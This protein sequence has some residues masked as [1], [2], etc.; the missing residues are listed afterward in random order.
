MLRVSKDSTHESIIVMRT[1]LLSVFSAAAIAATP[2]QALTIVPIYDASITSLPNAAVIEAAFQTVSNRFD[3][4]YA[5]NVTLK[6]PVGWGEVDGQPIKSGEVASSLSF[7]R[8]GYTY[9]SATSYLRAAAASNPNDRNLAS[10]VANLPAK[11]PTGKNSFSFSYAEAQVLG[12]LPATLYLNSGYV[13]FSSTVNWNFSGGAIPSGQYDFQGL[14]A[15]EIGE[16]LGRVSAL[17]GSSPKFA[18][19]LDLLRYSAPGVSS[20]SWSAPAYF[21]IDGGKTN[22]GAFNNIGG[23]DRGDWLGYNGDAQD[24]YLNPG[25]SYAFS[26]NDYTELD[27]LGWGAY[28]GGSIKS[29]DDSGDSFL[30]SAAA[31]PEP[32][33]WATMLLGLGLIGAATRR[34][35][36]GAASPA[37]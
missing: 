4:A 12:L 9:A 6:I 34:R 27:V 16:V 28:I 7:L 37:L 32:A 25:V 26:A 21:S 36:I 3:S 10:V 14:A 13:G 20:F 24:A 11:D 1:G 33:I 2:V 15:H 23:G 18:T 8:A 5:A 17:Q 30:I 19:I 29:L 22:L 35:T 31:V